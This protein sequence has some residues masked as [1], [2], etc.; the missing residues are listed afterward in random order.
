MSTN[1]IDANPAQPNAIAGGV[2]F[3]PPDQEAVMTAINTM[4]ESAVPA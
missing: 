2:T 1:P 3:S 4:S